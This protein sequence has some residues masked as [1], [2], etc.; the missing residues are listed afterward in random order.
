MKLFFMFYMVF[1]LSFY[2]VII[3]SRLLFLIFHDFSLSTNTYGDFHL[4]RRMTLSN[5]LFKVL[6]YNP[7]H[8]YILKNITHPKYGEINLTTI[9]IL[10]SP[11]LKNHILFSKTLTMPPTLILYCIIIN[12]WNPGLYPFIYFRAYFGDFVSSNS[13]FQSLGWSKNYRFWLLGLASW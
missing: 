11:N 9:F 12:S 6:R 8:L 7:F 10:G 13:S 4:R 2:K 3:Y 1:Q 5:W